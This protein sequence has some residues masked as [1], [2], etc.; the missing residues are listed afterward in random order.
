MVGGQHIAKALKLQFID[1]LKQ[2]YQLNRIPAHHQK[3]AAQVLVL[4][5]P[6]LLAR[7]AAGESQRVQDKSAPTN[8]ENLVSMLCKTSIARIA[9]IGMSVLGDEDLR[10][11]VESM[12]LKETGE[13]VCGCF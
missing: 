11:L 1:Y 10:L 7:L 2:G 6:L 12:G 3:V 4:K 8:T 9:R 5:T 13:T